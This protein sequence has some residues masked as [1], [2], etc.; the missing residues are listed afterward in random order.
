[1][2][3]LAWLKILASLELAR[4]PI[5]PIRTGTGEEG[6]ECGGGEGRDL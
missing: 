4:L 1:M 3:K 5:T 2:F 6:W